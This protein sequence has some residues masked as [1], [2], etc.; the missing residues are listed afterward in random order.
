MAEVRASANKAKK[1]CRWDGRPSRTRLSSMASE[2]SE[3]EQDGVWDPVCVH[4]LT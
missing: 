1:A 4:S 3:S 2:V